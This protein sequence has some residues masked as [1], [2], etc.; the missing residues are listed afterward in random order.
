[1]TRARSA[2]Y[3]FRMAAKK[4]RAP[5][6]APLET[7]TFATP[8]AWDHWL[9][10]HHVSARGLWLKLAKKG[11]GHA[12]MSYPEALEVALCWGWIDAVKSACDD[13][14]WLQKFT[15]RGPRSI[16]SKINRAKALALVASGA[17]KP[18][19]HAEIERAKKDGRWE[20]AY[21]GAKAA[22]VPED[23]A[24]ALAKSPRAA[25]FFASLDGAN[26]YAILFRIHNVKRAETRARKI[27]AFVQMLARG[28]KV[29]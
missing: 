14:W 23:L 22:T 3:T 18:P 20:A 13:A 25:K 15:P 28:E 27:A 17:M 8:E 29:H 2:L 19:G 1:V 12:S 16:W 9:S 10:R 11:T 26:R 7:L 5:A 24:A 4:S 21:D 6:V